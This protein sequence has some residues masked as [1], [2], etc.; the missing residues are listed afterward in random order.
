MALTVTT[1]PAGIH[2]LDVPA[3]RSGKLT[4]TLEFEVKE[5]DASL[6]QKILSGNWTWGDNPVY[7]KF[8]NFQPDST[9]PYVLIS[10]PGLIKI[11]SQHVYTPGFYTIKINAQNYRVPTP[12]TVLYILNLNVVGENAPAAPS[13]TVF[14]PILPRD[15][16]FPNQDQWSLNRGADIVVLESSVKMLLLTARGERLMEPT[17]GTRLKEIIFAFNDDEVVTFVNEE[18][19]FAIA[20][21]EP[22]VSINSIDV[23][24][25]GKKAYVELI[26]IS[27]L[28]QQPFPVTLE[29]NAL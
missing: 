14:G 1:I 8:A 26:L 20:Q 6:T 2:S 16:G 21:W 28:S 4:F 27:L 25:D 7:Q 24:K 18:I 11:S 19:R 29:F 3:G 10:Q 12:D 5:D 23:R 9:N 22:R 15:G 17:Y 13:E